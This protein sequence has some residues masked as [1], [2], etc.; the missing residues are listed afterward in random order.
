MSE[1][2]H[3]KRANGEWR[4]DTGYLY[5]ITGSVTD[6]MARI[7][8]GKLQVSNCVRPVDLLVAALSATNLKGVKP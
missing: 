4:L 7:R 1:K 6:Y 5:L 2:L 3:W 8:A